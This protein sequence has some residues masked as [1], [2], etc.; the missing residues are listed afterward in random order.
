[1]SSTLY[2]VLAGSVGLAI[3][4]MIVAFVVMKNKINKVKKEAMLVESDTDNPVLERKEYGEL[5]WIEKKKVQFPLGDTSLEFIIN[6]ALRNKY[7]TFTMV[8]FEDNANQRYIEKSLAELGKL[9]KAKT[10]FDIAILKFNESTIEKIDE[11][12]KKLNDKGMIFCVEASDKKDVKKITSYLKLTG[13]RNEFH[14]V[15]NG[16]ILIAK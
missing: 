1:M 5:L 10:G 16:I 6:T 13:I 14:K 9:K 12:Y 4:I 11:W 3:I 15:D 7:E 8:D 2:Y